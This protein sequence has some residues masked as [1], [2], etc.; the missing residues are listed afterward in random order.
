VERVTGRPLRRFL[1]EEISVPWKL[2][3]F[4]YGVP[5][6]R[7]GEVACNALTG[8]QLPPIA[9]MFQRSIGVD[10][11]TAVAYANDPIFLTS[12]VPA[13][14]LITTSDGGCRFFEGL[15][16]GGTL[17][18]VQIFEPRTVRRALAEQSFLEMD[19]SLGLPVRY[20]MGFMLGGDVFSVYGP[21]TTRAF[22]HVGF[23][24]VLLWADPDREL[25]AAYLNTGK[26]F[27]TLDQ[28]AWLAVPRAIAQRL[29]A[30]RGR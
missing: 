12:V 23:S 10:P 20:S 16:L 3:T 13:G 11:A 25:S 2:G 15:R 17:E 7:A 6:E 8:P 1:D 18:G 24:N 26:P 21:R 5:P 28:L 29:D 4:N 27:A 22:G 9:W 14:N 19:S 30:R